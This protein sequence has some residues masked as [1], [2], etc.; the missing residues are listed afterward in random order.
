MT[1]PMAKLK[2]IRKNQVY[3]KMNSRRQVSKL[4]LGALLL[5]SLSIGAFAEDARVK[6]ISFRANALGHNHLIVRSSDGKNWDRIED[7]SISISYDF[8]LKLQSN[9]NVQHWAVYGRRCLNYDCNTHPLLDN[10][11]GSASNKFSRNA[12][13]SVSGRQL[14]QYSPG[15]LAPGG[16]L[17]TDVR[18][19][20]NKA[21][22]RLGSRRDQAISHSTR[23]SMIANTRVDQS[24]AFH[25]GGGSAI[26]SGDTG[27][28]AEIT[29]SVVCKAYDKQF[30]SLEPK[31]TIEDFSVKRTSSA[32]ACPRPYKLNATFRLNS[33]FLPQNFSGIRPGQQAYPVKFLVEVNGKK[34]PRISRGIKIKQQQVSYSENLKLDPGTNTIRIIVKN[35]PTSRTITRKVNCGPLRLISSNLSYAQTGPCP[36]KVFETATFV[37]NQPGL[38]AFKIRTQ[39]GV[40]VH[41]G[42]LEIKRHGDIYKAVSVRQF[43][44]GAVNMLL[45]AEV[46][47][48]TSAASGWTPLKIKCPT[49]GPSTIAITAS[50]RAACPKKVSVDTRYSMSGI[51]QSTKMLANITCNNGQSKQK[52]IFMSPRTGG[53]MKL[54]FDVGNSTSLNCTTHLVGY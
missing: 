35:G 53:K 46:V 40:T 21:M 54:A 14:V 44:S 52:L 47:G 2:S 8:S 23:I 25:P 1:G 7:T 13:I 5:S 43:N 38:T 24:G 39:A 50:S 33:R 42:S 27:K 17:S 51:N 22:A 18:D 45:R 3:S 28:S 12:T 49:P 11:N 9:G 36:K 31:L 20:C 30:A 26:V 37:F 16:A 48:N 10:G 29:L 6:D 34:G 32:P 15:G 19:A 4:S 41:Q